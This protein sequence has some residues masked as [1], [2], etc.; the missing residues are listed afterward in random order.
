MVEEEAPANSPGECAPPRR[1]RHDGNPRKTGCAVA[2]ER[3]KNR[4]RGLEKTESR[5]VMGQ[6]EARQSEKKK[7]VVGQSETR[8]GDAVEFA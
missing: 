1:T 4:E 3:R 5:S 8:E 6:S 2:A 7:S